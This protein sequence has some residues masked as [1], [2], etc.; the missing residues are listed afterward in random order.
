[1]LRHSVKSGLTYQNGL[2]CTAAILWVAGA[3]NLSCAFHVASASATCNSRR[4][5]A[6][7]DVM[8]KLLA[9]GHTL[10]IRNLMSYLT[11]IYTV[12]LLSI[13]I[14][15]MGNEQV[16]PYRCRLPAQTWLDL[17]CGGVQEQSCS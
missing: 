11:F 13:M 3:Y 16:Q 9:K 14:G 6:G 4:H 10:L 8:I 5:D 15:R 17:R 12:F 7:C 1:M 2:A